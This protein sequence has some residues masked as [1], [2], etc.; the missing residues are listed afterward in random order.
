MQN[1]SDCDAVFCR[2]GTEEVVSALIQIPG[3]R[4]FAI[5]KLTWGGV[6]G[7][8]ETGRECGDMEKCKAVAQVEIGPQLLFSI[9]C[10]LGFTM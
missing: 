1:F 6:D 3:P 2:S 5:E 7:R 4:S 8:V 10:L 9:F